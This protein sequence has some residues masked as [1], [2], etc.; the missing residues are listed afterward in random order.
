MSARMTFAGV[1]VDTTT[2]EIEKILDAIRIEQHHGGDGPQLLMLINDL[3]VAYETLFECLETAIADQDGVSP[4]FIARQH[5]GFLTE[6][7]NFAE[8][9]RSQNGELSNAFFHF[10]E[11]GPYQTPAL[12]A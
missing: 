2:G 6:L 11:M 10:L 4:L 8:D 9:S 7:A 12:A 5:Q 3:C 1:T